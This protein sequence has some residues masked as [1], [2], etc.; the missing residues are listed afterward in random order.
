MNIC[1]VVG[2]VNTVSRP[3]SMS[4]GELDAATEPACMVY[5]MRSAPPGAPAVC[6]RPA[7]ELVSW[8]GDLLVF[9]WHSPCFDWCRG[10]P[11]VQGGWILP[12]RACPALYTLSS[13]PYPV[14]YIPALY[15]LLPFVPCTFDSPLHSLP[16][17][18]T[19]YG[20]HKLTYPLH[21]VPYTCMRT[22]ALQTHPP[23]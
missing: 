21:P 5:R 12:P 4:S 8:C 2:A 10:G 11:L 23:W 22:P 13:A 19:L 1:S 16:A 7:R 3:A 15:T 18:P 14:L 17:M 6:R 9:E 20:L